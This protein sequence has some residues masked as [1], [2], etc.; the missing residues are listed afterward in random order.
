MSIIDDVFRLT[1]GALK[2]VLETSFVRVCYQYC[3]PG[4][5]Q[6]ITKIPKPGLQHRTFKDTGTGLQYISS[7]LNILLFIFP[8]C[9]DGPKMSFE[10]RFYRKLCYCIWRTIIL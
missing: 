4:A 5:L 10:Q 1:K 9:P 8:S 3:T 2:N 6:Q 7:Y